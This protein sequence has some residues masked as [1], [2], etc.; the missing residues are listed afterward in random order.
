[1]ITKL[2]ERLL[3]LGYNSNTDAVELEKEVVWASLVKSATFGSLIKL[4]LI[5]YK[6]RLSPMESDVFELI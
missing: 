1:M 5:S 3:V 2:R 6:N 4:L